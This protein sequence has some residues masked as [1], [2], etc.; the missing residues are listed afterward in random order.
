M[1]LTKWTISR[2]FLTLR[3]KL[4]IKKKKNQ[5][6]ITKMEKNLRNLSNTCYDSQHRCIFQEGHKELIFLGGA[7]ASGMGKTI[8]KNNAGAWVL[9]PAHPR[10]LNGRFL[11]FRVILWQ[12]IDQERSSRECCVVITEK[13]RRRRRNN[14]RFSVVRENARNCRDRLYAN[15][16][17]E[18]SK[19]GCCD[20]DLI[21]RPEENGKS[22]WSV[23]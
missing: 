7:P 5:K 4:I 8:R 22:R 12:N 14:V 2:Y 20:G 9:F 18:R 23:R 11:R 15:Q 17:S 16:S 10:H 1:F 19:K 21:W 6:L 3:K 13:P